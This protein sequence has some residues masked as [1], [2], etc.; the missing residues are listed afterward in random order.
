M[1]YYSTLQ[2]QSRSLRG[3]YLIRF[4]PLHQP[5]T[6]ERSL[7]GMFIFL[8]AEKQNLTIHHSYENGSILVA[9]LAP[10]FTILHTLTTSNVTP[11]PITC[12]AWHASSS[13]Q[14]A[15]MLATQTRNGDLRVWTVAKSLDSDEPARVVRVLKNKNKRGD[16]WMAWSKNGRIVQYS[17]GYVLAGSIPLKLSC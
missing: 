9:A 3:Q 10:S 15:D 2:G 12:L 4:A 11:S 1:L 17:A 8:F 16:N 13:K 14:K 5:P 7:L 6:A